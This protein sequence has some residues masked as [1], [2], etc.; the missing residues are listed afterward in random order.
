VEPTFNPQLARGIRQSQQLSCTA[1][2]LSDAGHFGYWF[3]LKRHYAY[4]TIKFGICQA[5]SA[6]I[7]PCF[8]GVFIDVLG[9]NES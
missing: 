1:R 6:I 9:C 3:L 2:Q 4:D 5:K 7:L 8:H